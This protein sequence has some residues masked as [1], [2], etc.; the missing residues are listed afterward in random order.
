[1]KRFLHT[2]LDLPS[3]LLTVVLLPVVLPVSLIAWLMPTKCVERT[4]AE[5]ATYLREALD[6]TTGEF[7]WDEFVSAPIA[8]QRLEA[9]RK[10]AERAG[11][12][13]WDYARL[14]ALLAEVE[15]MDR[16]AAGSG[17]RHLRLLPPSR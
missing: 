16:A 17:P 4:P 6:E 10:Q 15:A 3:L 2:R 5:V 12:P 1:M 7:D 14:A 9:I 8:D 13:D 11:P